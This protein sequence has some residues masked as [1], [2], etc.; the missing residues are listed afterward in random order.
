[1]GSKT[2]KET[3]TMKLT[4]FGTSHGHPEKGRFCTSV[5]FE[6]KGNGFFIDAGA[7]IIYLLKQRG[8]PYDSIKALF[9][10][11]MHGDHTA[12]LPTIANSLW[13]HKEIDHWDI[14]LPDEKAIPA[15]DAWTG[16]QY[17]GGGVTNN[18]YIKPHVTTEGQ[19]YD[20][21]GIRVTAIPTAHVNNGARPSF[22]YMIETDDGKRVL[23]TGD[24]AYDFHD[25]PEVAKKEYFDLI[26]S[27]LVH[28]APDKAAEILKDVNTRL[29]I[30]S[31]LGAS[32]VKKLEEHNIR[33]N[34]PHIVAKDGFE[35]YVI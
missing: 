19:I 6:H 13:Y 21:Y 16:A 10:T 1:M 33:F 34:F 12:E 18:K 7:P 23:F 9:I 31:H 3:N 2:K 5:Y 11:H 24:L 15:L 35:Y 26:V 22:A 27:E 28:L 14:Y 29:L 30:F 20:E 25:F 17:N 4:F 32:N 8:I